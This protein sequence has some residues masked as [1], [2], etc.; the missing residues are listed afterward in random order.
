MPRGLTGAY[1]VTSVVRRCFRWVAIWT[2]GDWISSSVAFILARESCE[3]VS[4]A[5]AITLRFSN[6]LLFRP[7]FEFG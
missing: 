7:P 5:S 3:A 6:L 4:Y 1:K 2:A